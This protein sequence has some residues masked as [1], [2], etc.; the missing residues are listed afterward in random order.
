MGGKSM[1][2]AIQGII[3][4]EAISE[5]YTME[6]SLIIEAWGKYRPHS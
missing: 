5:S 4:Q 1:T 6:K 2:K 3:D